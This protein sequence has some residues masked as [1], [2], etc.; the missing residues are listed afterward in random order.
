MEGSGGTFREEVVDVFANDD[1][2]VL[3][4]LHTFERDG[5]HREYRTAHIIEFGGTAISMDRAPG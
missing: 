2:G 4:L 3:L 5:V 1:H